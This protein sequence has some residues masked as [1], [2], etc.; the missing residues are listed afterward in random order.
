MQSP[1]QNPQKGSSQPEGERIKKEKGKKAMSLKDA[2]EVSTKS[3]SDDETT[4]VPSYMVESSKKKDLKKFDFVTEDGEHVHLTKEQ[5]SAQKKIE[6]EV[7]AE[8]A[9]REGEMRKE[10]LI[11]LLSPEVV[12]KY[13]NDKLQYDRYYDKMLNKRAQLRITNCD[14]L[15]RK[16]LITLKVYR[17][18]DTSEIIPEFKAIDLHLGEWR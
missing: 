7:K 8:A 16:G 10:E 6:E 1:A 13:Y 15:T 9:R 3:V 18:D 4:R 11:D 17:E 2:E 14:I 5:I 12:N